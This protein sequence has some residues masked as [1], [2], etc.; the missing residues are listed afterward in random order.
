M[1]K[2]LTS[3][4]LALTLVLSLAFPATAAASAPAKS[5]IPDFTDMEF[6]GWYIT[7][8]LW[9]K[10][11]GF[12]K[13]YDDGRF[14]VG[15]ACTKTEALTLLYRV[16]EDAAG[17]WEDVDAALAWLA[18]RTG[19]RPDR[20]AFEGAENRLDFVRLMYLALGRG[21]K[22]PKADFADLTDA[23]LSAKQDAEEAVNWA[24]AKGITNGTGEDAFSPE[25]NLTREQVVT[26]L[27]RWCMAANGYV[28]RPVPVYRETMT[29]ER[30][31]LRFY[32]D[33]PNVPY[34]GI[35]D[36]YALMLPSA[37]M[38]VE[39][40]GSSYVLTSTTGT[41]TVDTEKDVFTSPDL[42]DFTNLMDQVQK[43]MPNV[44]Y[45]GNGYAAFERVEYA[46]DPT[47]VTFDFAKYHIDLRAD[48]GDVIFPLS[49]LSDIY[50]DLFYHVANFN[51]INFYVNDDNHYPT[52]YE[53]DEH[54]FDLLLSVTE[55]PADMAEFAYN[56]LC[57]AA[58]NN[59]GYPGRAPIEEAMAAK[60]MDAAL[61]ESWPEIRQML[62]STNLYEYLVGQLLLTTGPMFDGWHTGYFAA[63]D[64]F[65]FLQAEERTD[66][67]TAFREAGFDDAYAEV[68]KLYA[69]KKGSDREA[70]KAARDAAF[71]EGVTYIKKGDTV[72][73]VLDDFVTI[74]F[75]GWAAYR[76]GAGPLPADEDDGYVRFVH[77]LEKAEADPEVK[78]FVMDIS[79]N[80]GGSL[81]ELVS[82]T[83]QLIGV[84]YTR[85]YNPLTKRLLTEYYSVDK[86]L[87]GKIDEAD[88]AVRHDKLRYAVLTSGYCF[89][90]GNLF[91]SVMHDNGVMLLGYHSGGGSCA[92]QKM[93]AA[94][95]F[96]YQLSSHHG[97]LI[98]AA[99]EN[100][101]GG[102]PVDVELLKIN[103]DG[104]EDYSAFYDIDLLSR[105][106]DAFYAQAEKPAA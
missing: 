96:G 77:A 17:D 16:A 19:K 43:G 75:K 36:Y 38:K 104:A 87:D 14:G 76:E 90:C 15:Q 55:R 40:S 67:I 103:E 54:F 3:L 58:E 66:E 6:G 25:E 64:V 74:D 62:K 50:S 2:K 61:A 94:D 13:G 1:K 59:F 49:T 60:G 92:V 44:Y 48:D 83:E 37:E 73:F 31:E 81:D 93:C 11:N 101:D 102:I 29:N 71:G 41:A 65:Q 86:N 97:R 56:E 24:A 47:P 99:G 98:N 10:D 9:A 21:E 18:E 85:F 7:P 82:M 12:A 70:M 23:V 53:R 32:S 45:D 79:M 26:M 35:S 8:V 84:N 91:P 34:I 20:G 68:L 95:G 72:V 51:G 80:G 57:F 46:Q 27:Y 33:M 39:R 88:E 5:A 28:T 89:S 52:D 4:L 105:E 78:N 63:F 42:S 100:I 69:P 22:A 30:A 106:I